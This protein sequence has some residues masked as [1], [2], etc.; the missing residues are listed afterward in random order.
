MPIL[1]PSENPITVSKGTTDPWEKAKVISTII[2][3]IV[4]PVVL[5]WIGNGFTSSL[6]ERELRK[7]RDTI[8]I[9]T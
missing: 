7:Y 6:K 9:S 4:I 8:P 5:I 2:S 3:A 1:D